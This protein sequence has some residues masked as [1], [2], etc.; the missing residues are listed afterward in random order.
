MVGLGEE[1]GGG[2]GNGEGVRGKRGRRGWGEGVK[3]DRVMFKGGYIGY[4]AI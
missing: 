4:G 1:G 2:G 3:D